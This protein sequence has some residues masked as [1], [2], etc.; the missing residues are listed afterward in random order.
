VPRLKEKI[1]D[2]IARIVK[3]NNAARRK[4]RNRA[5]AKI[6]FLLAGTTR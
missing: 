6:Y 5:R 1:K 3:K 4:K 2:G